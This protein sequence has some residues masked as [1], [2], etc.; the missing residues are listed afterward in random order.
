MNNLY[1]RLVKANKLS[2]IYQGGYNLIHNKMLCAGIAY[3]MSLTIRLVIS[4]RTVVT[5]PTDNDYHRTE[6]RK[7]F[8]QSQSVLSHLL[9]ANQLPVQ[10][11]G[12]VDINILFTV[13][14]AQKIN[15]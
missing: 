14:L 11:P 6:C 3:Y 7:I 12:S 2:L 10:L 13:I 4:D 9:P 5:I 15:Y 1:S 8:C